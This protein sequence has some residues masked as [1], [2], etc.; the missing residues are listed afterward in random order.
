MVSP[1][2]K[3]TTAPGNS[4]ITFSGNDSSH[5]G[6]VAKIIHRVGVGTGRR[7][8]PVSISYE[9]IA[10]EDLEARTD[11]TTELSRVESVNNH[12]RPLDGSYSRV[13]VLDTAVDDRN[14]GPSSQ[15]TILVQLLHT[16]DAMDRVIRRSSIIAERL[17][18]DRIQDPD[19]RRLVDRGYGSIAAGVV[20]RRP[21][22]VLGAGVVALDAH[23]GE[24]VRVEL[25][26]DPEPGC[27]RDLV[28]EPGALGAGLELHDVPPRH[29]VAGRRGGLVEIAARGEVDG[30]PGAARR[31]EQGEQGSCRAHL[32][33]LG[34]EG[35]VELELRGMLLRRDIILEA[36][37]GRTYNI[38]VYTTAQIARRAVWVPSEP[39]LVSDGGIACHMSLE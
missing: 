37:R 5:M 29:G 30:R 17:T 19:E 25:L 15:D 35:V 3:K 39:F 31:A 38:V 12:K 18:L 7:V 32:H 36:Q 4:L 20:E 6:T 11:A 33:G 23:A 24:E 10:T 14:S 28:E 21:E 9:V 13:S 26:D 2:A 1:N 16:S 8:R 22:R 27:A 34:R